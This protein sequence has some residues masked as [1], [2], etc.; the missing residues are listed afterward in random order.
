VP[1]D[2][3]FICPLG[4]AA[5]VAVIYDAAH[6]FGTVDCGARSAKA[7]LASVYSLHATKVMPGVEGGLVVSRDARLLDEVRR[8][9]NHGLAPD[10]LAS[11]PGYNAKMDELSAAVALHSLARFEESLARRTG[12]AERLREHL[13]RTAPSFYGVQRIPLAVTT[14]HQNLAVTCAVSPPADI[15]AVVATFLRHGVEARRYF[16]PALHDLTAW[17]GRFR[18]PVTDRLVASL[19]CLPLHSRMSEDDLSRIEQAATAVARE[20]GS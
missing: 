4:R 11:G 13:V 17:R 9:R 20:L 16:W 1:P 15:E 18:L 6:A 7:P 10:R 8:L 5:R 14:N 12:Y 3:D 19:V 2:L